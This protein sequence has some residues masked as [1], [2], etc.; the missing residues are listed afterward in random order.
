[1]PH[2][3]MS[4]LQKVTMDVKVHYEKCKL[5]VNPPN[6]TLIQFPPEMVEN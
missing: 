6:D 5:N 3:T 1:M 2:H 4:C